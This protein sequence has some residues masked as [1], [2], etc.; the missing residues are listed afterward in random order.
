MIATRLT[1]E[2]GFSLAELAVAIAVIAVILSGLLTLQVT[3]QETYLTGSNQVESQESGRL[4]L[5]R[6]ITEI[7][8]AGNDPTH[9]TS[10]S[11]PL[12]TKITAASASGFTINNDWSGDGAINNAASYTVNGTARGEQVTYSVNGSQLQRQESAIDNAPQV[13]IDGVDNV[14]F[15]YYD[16]THT[17]ACPTCGVITNPAA[18]ASS[19]VTIGISLRTRPIDQPSTSR[20]RVWVTLQDEVRIRN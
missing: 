2:R 13:V 16:S 18:N 19:I 4:A 9:A 14:T 3:G 1:S 12:W 6:M 17:G 10:G 11:P 7:R 5:Q 15:T 8:G 20:G